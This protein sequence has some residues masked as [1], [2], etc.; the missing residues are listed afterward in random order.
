MEGDLILL[1]VLGSITLTVFG[2]FHSEKSRKLTK[3]AI[4]IILFFTVIA[5]FLVFVLHTFFP[6]PI[7]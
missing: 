7:L 4:L 2:W 3:F 6:L 5:L 1:L